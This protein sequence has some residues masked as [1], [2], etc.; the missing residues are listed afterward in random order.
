MEENDIFDLLSF[1]SGIDRF[2]LNVDK[3]LPTISESQEL[4]LI[5]YILTGNSVAFPMDG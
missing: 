5:S 2:S 3:K 1:E 4:V